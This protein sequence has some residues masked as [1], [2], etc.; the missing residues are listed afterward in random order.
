LTRHYTQAPDK[1]WK[2]RRNLEPEYLL[3]DGP[4]RFSRNPMFLGS[5]A[6]WGGWSIWFGSARVAAGLLVVTGTMR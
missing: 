4:Y 5:I 6:V 3:T 1:S 2:I